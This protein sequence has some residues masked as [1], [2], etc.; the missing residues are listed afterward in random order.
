LDTF[1]N[2]A[3][4]QYTRSLRTVRPVNRITL[5]PR[6]EATS[7]TGDSLS[8]ID[9]PEEKS[10]NLAT[11]FVVRR[12][13]LQTDARVAHLAD[14]SIDPLRVNP[15]GTL[16]A[17]LAFGLGDRRGVDR[18]GNSQL[19]RAIFYTAKLTPPSNSPGS[20]KAQ[21][22]S[23][24]FEAQ[25][26]QQT[27]W[28]RQPIS[29]VPVRIGSLDLRVGGAPSKQPESQI[30]SFRIEE[31]SGYWNKVPRLIG[32]MWLPVSDVQP[33]G[34]DGL[35]A[36][37][38]APEGYSADQS[39]P[40]LCMERRFAGDAPVVIPIKPKAPA[41]SFLLEVHEENPT[42]YSETVFL[43]LRYVPAEGGASEISNEKVRVVIIDADPFLVA[44]VEYSPLAASVATGSDVVALWNTGAV[45]GQSWQLQTN[46]RPFEFLLPSQGIG[47]EMPKAFELHS[48]NGDPSGSVPPTNKS[49][50]DKLT[51]LDFRFSPVARQ[52]LAASYTP[53]NFTE[54]PWNLRRILGYPGQRDAGAGVIEL[55]YELLYGLSCSVDA[56]LLRLAE[57]F[58]L[59]GRIPGRVP[60]RYIP[61]QDGTP[62][63]PVPEQKHLYEHKRWLWSL[64]AELY[65]K[66]VAIFETRTS[67]SNYGIVAGAVGAST[68]PEELT[69]SQGVSCSLR[70]SSDLYYSVDPVEIAKVDQDT[71]PV[72][73]P[74]TALKGGVSWPF[75]SPRLFHATVRNPKSSSAAVTGLALSS[76]GGSGTAKAGFD[77][78]LSSIT[79][80]TE[81]GRTSKLS[82][83]RLGR[84]GVFHN[85]ARY[86]IEYERD[87]SVSKQFNKK[88]TPFEHRPVL[89]KVREFVEILEPIASLSS[90]AQMYP[91]AGCVKSIEFKQQI[92]PVSGAWSSNV[93]S[94][95]W[96]IPLWYKPDSRPSDPSLFRYERP[97]VVFNLAG[98]DG[99]DVECTIK[100][101]D[102][103]YFYTDTDANADSD[104]HNWPVVVGVDFLPVPLP[105]PNPAFPTS[106]VHEIPAHDS[107]VPFGLYEFTHEIEAGHGRVNLVHGRSTQSIGAT[108]SSVTLQRGPQIVSSTQ[109]K[110]QDLRDQVRNDLFNVVRQD[111]ANLK[112]PCQKI[113]D[114]AKKFTAGLG[115]QFDALAQAVVQKEDSLLQAYL[116]QATNA[117]TLL[118]DELK[119]QLNAQ[120][121]QLSNHKLTD[122]QA[123]IESGI[124][125]EIDAFAQRF[126]GIPA[127]ANAMQKFF[128][129]VCTTVKDAQKELEASKSRL[130]NALDTAQ[131]TTS[132][133]AAQIEKSLGDLRA[134]LIPPIDG[135]KG[136]LG[137]VRARVQG[138]AESWMPGVSF[139]C[140]Q[141]EGTIFPALSAAEAVLA[142]TETVLAYANAGLDNQIAGAEG[143]LKDALTL[144][145]GQVASIKF[146]AVLINSAETAQKDASALTDYVNASPTKM[147][148]LVDGWVTEAGKQL[149]DG[150]IKGTADLDAIVDSVAKEILKFFDPA[151]TLI[152]P[153]KTAIEKNA[154][155]VTSTLQGYGTQFD[156]EVCDL[157]DKLKNGAQH[158][159]ESLRRSLEEGVGRFAEALAKALPLDDIKLPSG[160]AVPALL[161]CAFGSVPSIQNLGFSLPNAGYFFG[162]LAPNVNM[163]P[164]L[165]AVK[166]LV[167]NLSPLSTL[168]P[169][170]ALSDRAMPVPH[171]PNFDLSN[172]FPD[173]A[174]LKLTNLFPALKMPPGS[175]D[176]VKVTHGIDEQSRVAWVQADID[177]KTDT[178]TIFSA[179]PMAF[180][181]A[182]PRFTSRVRAQVASSGQV[183]KETTGAITGDWHLLIGGSPMITFV[184][185]A[186][187]FDKDGKLHVDVSPDRVQLSAAL[188]FVQEIIA[189]Y[190][191]PDGGFGIFPSATGIETRLA[192]PI[193]DTSLGTTGITNLTFNFLFGLSWSPEFELY[194]GFGLASPDAPFNVSVYILGGGGHLLAKA[195]YLPGKSL[196]C[197]LDM[198]IDASAALSIALGPISGNVHINLGMRFQFNTGRGDLSLGI[199]LLIGGEVS[200]L[201]IISASIL[202]RLDA[203]YDNGVFTC[204]GLFSISI[205]ICWCFTLNVSQQVSCRL[206][207]GGGLAYNDLPSLWEENTAPPLVLDAGSISSVPSRADLDTYP[208]LAQQYLQL[209]S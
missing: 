121:G 156:K 42:K 55:N 180:Q 182:T 130:K 2:Q 89:R 85:L 59:V 148:A 165:T 84:I 64:Y 163:T 57:I 131:A 58:A 28:K 112:D 133:D 123:Q 83:A 102:R 172:I 154:N 7:R 62:V 46:S 81:I 119:G 132:H 56:P 205:K 117:V 173:F 80:V 49:P 38:Y 20:V 139:V 95:G 199:F 92:I 24:H 124:N 208:A 94:S 195:N 66:R 188:S 78:D 82:V 65:S 93:G 135:L 197:S 4:T 204:R 101:A 191:S 161:N 175:S 187:T 90:P 203:T 37:E 193:P 27:A 13:D 53:Q 167:P 189:R 26:L 79:S 77:K 41:G 201:G 153:L 206:G 35:P 1:W 194:T 36:S 68:G 177:L 15:L 196:T 129:R 151:G 50:T 3:L 47:E 9:H 10:F 98:A 113:C 76:M 142:Q 19:P 91:G 104:P 60:L 116:T 52:R 127:S 158:E 202:L 30:Q 164:V 54:A 17:V 122:V 137:E 178:A 106:A 29:L 71:F 103:L 150:V 184:S 143:A 11:E 138:A 176:A 145:R 152:Q 18:N 21:D 128:S 22:S 31:L 44:A 162:Q 149:Q 14:F 115:K 181:I 169:S 171:L 33:G 183:S 69:I 120:S 159:L 192:L 146:P 51:A 105:A 168:V 125:L 67:G 108:L 141:W 61:L 99:S 170:F 16:D 73:H 86:V 6:I 48:A 186:I 96:K 140:Q 209:I 70:G 134:Q 107:P 100:S 109:T 8:E 160:A 111:P 72:P 110:L 40:E 185:T 88:Q 12:R 157:A 166:E 207:S 97:S 75:E 32:D 25:L 23:L 87:T 43:H 147:K 200:V 190:T 45:D 118:A 74:G 5:L 63:L 136:L 144:A 39:A 126:D 179:G 174:G 34:Q 155:A 198:A 114:A